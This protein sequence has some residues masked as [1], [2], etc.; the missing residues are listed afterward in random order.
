[1]CGKTFKIQDIISS[2]GIFVYVFEL[3]VGPQITAFGPMGPLITGQ[4]EVWMS[5]EGYCIN[6]WII[7]LHLTFH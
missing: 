1:M 4:F 7:F 3:E 5:A 6:L 2:F